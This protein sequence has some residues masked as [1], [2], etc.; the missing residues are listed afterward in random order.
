MQKI[1]VITGGGTGLGQSLAKQLAEQNII[2]YIIGRR[3]HKLLETQAFS[4]NHIIPITA[5]VSLPEERAKI[6]TKLNNI[7]ID[8][9][10]HNAATAFPII[11]LEKIS[12]RSEERRVG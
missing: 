11:P 2:V 9:L 1:A 5:D 12:L 3:T 6:K 7:K 10:I 4:P 8:Y